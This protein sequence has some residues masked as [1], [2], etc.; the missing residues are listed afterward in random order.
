MAR[1]GWAHIYGRLP[2]TPAPASSRRG[3]GAH[4]NAA[5]EVIGTILMVG[6]TVAVAASLVAMITF[7]DYASGDEAQASLTASLDPGQDGDWGTG[8][9]M[10]QV[11]HAGGE[12]LR[13]EEVVVIAHVG[14]TVHRFSDEEGTIQHA[15]E[16]VFGPQD[17]RFSLGE[18][19]RS[20]D[21]SIERG[22]SVLIDLVAGVEDP[23]VIWSGTVNAPRGG[24]Q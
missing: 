7:T 20:P 12:A 8:D 16:D 5:S 17:A 13:Q 22:S 2:W 9:E 11:H 4:D 21:L 15:Q 6:I 3:G 23:R 14:P 19:W 24:T 1:R 10:L 18:R